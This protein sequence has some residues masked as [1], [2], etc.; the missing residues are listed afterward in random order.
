MNR[1]TAITATLI[2]ALNLLAGTSY[3]RRK[4]RKGKG[5]GRG[6]N[7]RKT[8]PIVS[9]KISGEIAL[10][11]KNITKT[12]KILSGKAYSF[13]KAVEGKISSY[14]GQTITVYGK[15]IKD[16]IITIESVTVKPSSK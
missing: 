3:G 13:S 16:K 12:Y 10:T 7:K 9:K 15:V 14:V 4:K 8:T 5:K 2:T 6:N 1:R 11:E